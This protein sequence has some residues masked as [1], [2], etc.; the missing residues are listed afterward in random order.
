MYSSSSFST[1]SPYDSRAFRAV[2]TFASSNSGDVRLRGES[3]TRG[4]A[5]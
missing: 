1:V 5:R 4:S 3:G 2:L